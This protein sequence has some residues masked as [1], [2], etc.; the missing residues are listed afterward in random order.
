MTD[1]VEATTGPLGQGIANAVGQALGLKILATKFNSEDFPIFN[2][3]VYCLAGDGCIM[4]GISSEAS[5]F[6]GHLGLDNLVLVYDS[7]KVTLDGAL[8]ECCSEDTLMRYRSYNWDVFEID[9]YDL[10]AMDQVF[11]SIQKNQ[12]KPCFVVMHTIIG[13]GSPHKAGTYKVHGSPLGAEEVIATKQA[14]G[15]PEEAFYVPQSVTTFFEKKLPKEAALEQKWKEMVRAWSEA[16]PKLY[17]E[18]MEMVEKKLPDDLEAQLRKI[19]MKSPLAGR[20]A[21]QLVISLLADLLP[22]LVGG[23]ADLSGSDLTMIKKYGI[24]SPGNFAG[25]NLKY[26]VREFA[27]AGAAAGLAQTDMITPFVGTF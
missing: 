1:G 24:I 21:S 25:R 12:K 2:N 3:K 5:S 10:D 27:M 18:F 15:L 16:Q 22:Q 23:S 11:T 17:S 20:N 7:N 13:K 4:E 9:G 8:P 6:A 19:E 26:G 14:L